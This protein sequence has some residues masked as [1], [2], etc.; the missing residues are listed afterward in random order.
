MKA[1]HITQQWEGFFNYL[2]GYANIE[3]Y[4]HVE[5]TME[6]SITDNSFVGTSREKE[7]QDAFK[8]PAIAKGFIDDEKMSFMMKYPCVYCKD[9]FGNIISDKSSEHPD[10][11]YLGCFDSD[12][13]TI[14]GNWE[15]TVYEEK[16]V[17][18]Y[19]EELLNGTFEMRRIN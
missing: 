7:S 4:K 3:H 18:G 15:M 13:K 16:Y 17:G 5:F 6:F 2:E 14:S 12:K 8:K 10:I 11:H 9:D 1:V 19:L